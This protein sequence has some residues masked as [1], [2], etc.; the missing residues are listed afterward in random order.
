MRRRSH[1]LPG[2]V[3]TDHDFEVPLDHAD[4]ERARIT[5]FARELVATRRELDDLPWLVYFQGGPGHEALRPSGTDAWLGRALEDHRVLLLD[6]RGTGRSSPVNRQTLWRLGDARAQADHLAHHRADAIVRDAECI[7][8]ELIGESGKWSV[9]G[10]SFGGFCVT[11]YLSLA[12]GG[13]REAFIAGGLPPLTAG[14][15]DVYRATSP[16]VVERNRRFFSRYPDD[17]EV[18]SAVLSVLRSGAVRLPA[19]DPLS[20]RRFQTLGTRLG[21]S[22]GFEHLHYLLEGAFVPGP[23]GPELSERFLRGVETATSFAANPL[24]AVL[25]E[26][27]YCQGAAS[28]WAAERVRAEFPAFDPEPA[29]PPCFTGEMIYPWMFEEDAALAPFQAAANLLA[30]RDDW[31]AL[32]DPER[33]RTNEVPCAAVVY[34]DD[35]YVDAAYS[36]ET[37][38]TI[39][40]LRLWITNEYEHDGSRRDGERVLA[41]LID[42]ARGER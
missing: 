15:E 10:E 41:R 11:T 36:L 7:R 39:A 14:A 12:P 18:A 35:M 42:L 40:G 34:H 1:R 27:I 37:A 22:G 28:R 29:G 3:L 30:D 6:Q 17:A 19:G 24:Y 21:V 23:D 5:V 26:P 20:V 9:F 31:P 25:H 13:L 33:L 4:P 2:V 32:Y 8:R 16:R 38:R